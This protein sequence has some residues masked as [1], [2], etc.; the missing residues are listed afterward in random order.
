MQ[1]NLL[2]NWKTAFDLDDSILHRWV[3]VYPDII[4]ESYETAEV[5]TENLVRRFIT[6]PWVVQTSEEAFEIYLQAGELAAAK[7]AL[8]FF[9]DNE[10]GPHIDE[11]I[12]Q[13]KN[14]WE[15]RYHNLLSDIESLVVESLH[16]GITSS[17]VTDWK[18]YRE[19]NDLLMQNGRP[20]KAIAFMEYAY[21]RMFG[22]MN[23]RT[24]QVEEMLFALQA[25]IKDL[26]KE[27]DQDLEASRH[28]HLA[29]EYLKIGELVLAQSAIKRAQNIM[30][31][32]GGNTRQSPI[33]NNIS[34]LQEYP[35]ERN[36]VIP[37]SK[38]YSSDSEEL[39][40]RDPGEFPDEVK[41]DHVIRWMEDGALPAYQQPPGWNDFLTS[42]A[43]SE[44]RTGQVDENIDDGDNHQ[45]VLKTLKHLKKA[46]E[47]AKNSEQIKEKR[48]REVW[49]AFFR[50]F[51]R[52]MDLNT[53][54]AP[55]FFQSLKNTRG[56]L[57]DKL[58]GRPGT[59]L[60]IQGSFINTAR[61]PRGID[62][63]AW[64]DPRDYKPITVRPVI[65]SA[66]LDAKLGFVFTSVRV[67]QQILNEF[68]RH[69]PS[70]A[71]F[72]E[73]RILKVLLARDSDE[74]LTRFIVEAAKQINP[75]VINP[76][77]TQGPVQHET[78][79]FGRKQ[80]IER[81][82]NP[83][84]PAIVYGGRK[85]GKSS[86]LSQLV[87]RFESKS[88]GK[89]IALYIPIPQ[90]GI[91]PGSAGEVLTNI[92]RHL[93]NP[94]EERNWIVD[95]YNANMR[96]KNGL[97]FHR[98]LDPDK[99]PQQFFTQ[100][101]DLLSKFQDHHFLFLL[102]EADAF[103][104]SQVESAKNS[105]LYDWE[106]SI[107]WQLRTLRHESQ[108]RIDFI[109]AGFQGIARAARDPGGAFVNFRGTDPLPLSVLSEDDARELI[110]RPLQYLGLRFEKRALI[111]RILYYTGRHPALLQQFCSELFLMN[112][113]NGVITSR[114]IERVF[115]DR[116]FRKK[117]YEVINF[118]LVPIGL[119]R[120]KTI[121]S[122][123]MYIWVRY[124]YQSANTSGLLNQDSM[125]LV[126][127]TVTAKDIYQRII[128]H[129]P[130]Q[131]IEQVLRYDEVESYLDD[132]RVLGV[133]EQG[134]QGY[135]I[136]N[137]YFAQI[138]KS[139]H[140]VDQEINKLWEQLNLIS[141]T[142]E[143][144]S[145]RL[146]NGERGLLPVTPEDESRITGDNKIRLVFGS[147]GAGKSLLL[148]WLE[149][150]LHTGS[151]NTRIVRIEC[152][153]LHGSGQLKEALRLALD[154]HPAADWNTM[155]AFIKES[156]EKYYLCFE[157]IDGLVTPELVFDQ[158]ISKFIKT[159][160]KPNR[161]GL[162]HH[163]NLLITGGMELARI[164]VEWIQE[165]D[166][167][168][169]PIYLKRYTKLDQDKWMKV[170]AIYPSEEG[171][172]HYIW[173]QCQGDFRILNAF[174]SYLKERENRDTPGEFELTRDQFDRFTTELLS[175]TEAD[176]KQ[177]LVNNADSL[178]QK[179]LAVMRWLADCGQKYGDSNV[180]PELL[181]LYIDEYGC[182]EGQQWNFDDLVI[183]VKAL[184]LIDELETSIDQKEPIL[185]RIRQD[186]LWLRFALQNQ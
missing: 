18:K 74:R 96:V 24:N 72:D 33:V 155:A 14:S 23:V 89:H 117:I 137:R 79:F 185:G 87:P 179:A 136:A 21:S 175:E 115:L 11:E 102:D 40:Y 181:E 109:F 177:E 134:Q 125:I 46:Q 59:Q 3:A 44:L 127:E 42:W 25:Q 178:D 108:G 8:G 6:R 139:E 168:P 123:I 124:S 56:L 63:I 106:Q 49:Q 43:V 68:S 53:N 80:E 140:D 107:G 121:L 184:A 37:S 32:A 50:Q 60:S 5:K 85:L 118:N 129:F 131:K 161:S 31:S 48:N 165:L 78:M 12:I 57:S 119:D 66:G 162:N 71:V 170:N 73:R 97:G 51:L 35:S 126:K 69:L 67:P 116:D 13:K 110:A 16:L 160:T 93:V 30:E 113:P 149:D 100:M 156:A 58:G 84:G 54:A 36:K 173:E 176:W 29:S 61:F 142:A 133:V 174:L 92:I 98:Y 45:A 95:P 157:D 158:D 163:C 94:L 111:E 145:I 182:S 81:L 147:R 39:Y 65:G 7:K 86:L 27:D 135:F 52:S 82:M 28:L 169:L 148:S 64:P 104:E 26:G 144:N 34:S 22:D 90:A 138:L 47:L 153:D 143:R 75:Q 141:K 130:E 19:Q 112:P 103:L 38:L 154:C 151:E 77:S 62:L 15:E 55:Q 164:W 20:G 101:H 152:Q 122:L 167:R 1:R 166:E 159:I 114:Q 76:Y 9:N 120:S 180:S 146:Q 186:D 128:S 2:D 91:T 4:D 132:L 70:W 183:E 83:N 99:P 150:R 171:L 10:I 105:Q 88:D 41:L 17:I 172:H